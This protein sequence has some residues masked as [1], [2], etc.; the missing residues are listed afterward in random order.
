MQKTTLGNPVLFLDQDA[1]HHGDL[2]R[3]AAKAQKRNPQ[4]DPEGFAEADA[5]TE[6]FLVGDFLACWDV[7]HFKPVIVADIGDDMHLVPVYFFWHDFM[8]I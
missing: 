2:S 1:V 8:H 7:R 4:P 5:V 3:R 6:F